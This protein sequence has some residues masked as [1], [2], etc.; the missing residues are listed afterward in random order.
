MFVS[1]R[2]SA[3]NREQ[4]GFP[5]ITGE[6]FLYNIQAE[7]TGKEESGGKRYRFRGGRNISFIK[8]AKTVCFSIIQPSQRVGILNSYLRDRNRKISHL[9]HI[10]FTAE[11]TGEWTE[12]RPGTPGRPKAI[13][14]GG[15]HRIG[16]RRPLG[17]GPRFLFLYK[18]KP[19]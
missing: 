7:E 19:V 13:L 15:F 12:Y 10:Y 9:S 8:K 2:C 14:P 11:G 16:D 5:V 17:H 6:P 3:K 4:P 18:E 1:V